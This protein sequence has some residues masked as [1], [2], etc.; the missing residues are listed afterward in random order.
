M[1]DDLVRRADVADRRQRNACRTSSR[2]MGGTSH[3][4]THG[5]DLDFWAARARDPPPLPELRRS[6]AAAGRLLGGDR[7]ADGRGVPASGWPPT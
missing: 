5:V 4:L 1:E 6:G 7:P 2:G 3:L